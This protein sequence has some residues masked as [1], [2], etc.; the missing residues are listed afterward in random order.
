MKNQGTSRWIRSVCAVVSVACGAYC[1]V[2]AAALSL[3]EGR[4]Y[5]MV[6]PPYKGGYAAS[7]INAVAPNGE[8]VVF[9]TLGA[10]DGAPAN[11]LGGTYLA[12][13]GLLGWSTTPLVVPAETA[14]L[15]FPTLDFSSDL[16]SALFFGIP[17]ANQGAAGSEGTRYE[18]LLHPTGAPDIPSN[19][20]IAG[21]PLETLEKVS[22]QPPAYVGASPDL[23]HI[24][25]STSFAAPFV[26]EAV[27]VSPFELLYEL[28]S[29]V[30][31]T[32]TLRLVGLN[33]QEKAIDPNCNV[34]LGVASG[35]AS[36]TDAIANG[37]TEIFFTTCAG[38]ASSK[39]LFVRLGSTKTIEVSRPFGPC[40]G[41]GNHLPGE[42]PCEGAVTRANPEFNGASEDGSMVFFSTT[43]PLVGDDKDTGADLY[44]ARIG[45]PGGGTSCE[46]AQREVTAL[47]RVSR[48]SHIGEASQVQ[49]VVAV[50]PDGSHVYFVARGALI[51]TTNT[52]GDVPIKGADNIYVYDSASEELKFIASLCSGAHVSGSAQDLNCP[53]ET[54]IIRGQ[55]TDDE[56]LWR[57]NDVEAQTTANGAFLVFTSYGEL[58]PNDTDTAKDVYRYD[59]A[60][61]ALIR[62]SLGEAGYGA[63]GNRDDNAGNPTGLDATIRSRSLSTA[64]VSQQQEMNS[65]AI[66]E[67]GT[68]VV[69][70]SAEPLSPDA[71]NGGV[72]AYEW[73]QEGSGSQGAVALVST[74]SDQEPVSEVM[75]ASQ[76]RDLFFTTVQGLLPQDTDGAPDTY[77]A[78]L[79]GGFPSAPALP[80][81]CSGDGCQGPLTNPAPLL[82]PGSVSQAPGENL[83]PIKKATSKKSKPPKKATAR[84][85][86]KRKRKA[87]GAIRTHGR[88][89]RTSNGGRR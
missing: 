33:N 56:S 89:Q 27:G 31:G 44:M 6:S 83:A 38:S 65:R 77:D 21:E 36:A 78:R 64:S 23:S 51:T 73:H 87:N 3:P 19:F 80:Q 88:T 61:G 58:V 43:E 2:P 54:H 34:T 20:E 68:R 72:N 63:N 37:G 76:G 1:Y 66:T 9:N 81:P 39:Q 57:E 69:F 28:T 59:S 4:V 70:T 32:H 62:V 18:Y 24:I 10:F 13:R 67:D 50:S 79:E 14:P 86:K 25:F 15:A 49:S 74:G 45:C 53:T 55:F 12:R 26:P 41:E 84:R 82:V 11:Q 7:A 17:A 5:E 29:H 8:S 46:V 30:A 60:T 16:G 40:I 52:N 48:N 22:E 47:T 85:K 35:K 42:V 75:L 71:T